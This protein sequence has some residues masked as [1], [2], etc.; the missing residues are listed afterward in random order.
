M[1]HT[2]ETCNALHGLAD[3]VAHIS[4]SKKFKPKLSE[5]EYHQYL[6]LKPNSQANHLS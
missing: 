6:R 3:K 5:E 1:G 4:K 2:Q